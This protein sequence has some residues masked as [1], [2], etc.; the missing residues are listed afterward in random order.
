MQIHFENFWNNVGRTKVSNT[1]K[2]MHKTNINSEVNDYHRQEKNPTMVFCYIIFGG[3]L[4]YY[5]FSQSFFWILKENIACDSKFAIVTQLTL[6]VVV[7]VVKSE[8][9]YKTNI[10]QCFQLL[11]T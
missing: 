1:K 9:H 7:V 11:R 6:T 2:Y 4:Q 3:P 10:F 5:F 8:G